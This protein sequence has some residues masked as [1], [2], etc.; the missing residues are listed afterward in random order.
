MQKGQSDS[1]LSH[2]NSLASCQG[3]RGGEG[4]LVLV[5]GDGGGGGGHQNKAYVTT[6][7]F[8]CSDRAFAASLAVF[9]LRVGAK[10]DPFL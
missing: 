7:H 4:V 3:S 6:C 8:L 9:R 2:S 5:S 10:N 1:L